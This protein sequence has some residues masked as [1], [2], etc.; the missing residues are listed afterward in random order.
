MPAGGSSLPAVGG[1]FHDGAVW[2]APVLLG[3]TSLTARAGILSS[4]AM[5]RV[6]APVT[7]LTARATPSF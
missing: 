2:P 7:L 6:A 3:S 1:G 5:G 4:E